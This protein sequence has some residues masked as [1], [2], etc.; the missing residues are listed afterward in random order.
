MIDL[1]ELK[2]IV[3]EQNI[4]LKKE[5]LVILTEGNV[6]QLTDDRKLM[7]IKPSG[8]S[9]EKM[10]PEDMVV[11]DMEGGVVEGTLK[12][13]VDTPIHLAV[14]NKF[15]E[16]SG[17]CHA[18]SVY[19]TA[20]AQAKKDLPCYGTTHA[21]NFKGTIRVTRDLTVPEIEIDYE[22]NIGKTINEILDLDVL[23]VLVASH[24][25]FTF[26][27]SASQAVD[28][29]QVLEKT[30]KMAAILEPSN[31]LNVTTLA[32]KHYYRKQGDKRYYGQ[33]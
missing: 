2:K 6:S 12:P 10:R 29:M 32:A 1:N 3:C 21:D 14:Y 8:V 15:P 16:I 13:S 27:V 22:K 4:R 31:P 20:F 7:V 30:A 25:P 5:N 17:I 24:G 11:V 33:N 28:N 18:H 9:Y 19:A 26:G 23:A